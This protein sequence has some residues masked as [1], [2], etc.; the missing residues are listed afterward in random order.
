MV[1][2]S[3]S[4]AICRKHQH[5]LQILKQYHRCMCIVLC[6]YCAQNARA[7]NAK[8]GRKKN[9]TKTYFSSNFQFLNNVICTFNISAVMQIYSRIPKHYVKT[10][11]SVLLPQ[12]VD[13]HIFAHANK[14]CTVH[15]IGPL[16]NRLN[17]CKWANTYTCCTTAVLHR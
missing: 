15:T 11:C 3:M 12:N 10:L 13:W 16:T 4:L 6:A 9:N 5:V 7:L 14:Q 17:L 8:I 1:L 2:S